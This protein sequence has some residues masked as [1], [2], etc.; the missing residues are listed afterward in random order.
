MTSQNDGSEC[1]LQF[2]WF[3][4]ITNPERSLL[5]QIRASLFALIVL[6]VATA[7]PVEK[8]EPVP[9]TIVD[10]QPNGEDLETA[11]QHHGGG[12][13]GGGHGGGG[14]G[15]GGHGG[16]GHGGGGHH[17]GGHHGGGSGGGG[18]HH[19]G[20]FGGGGHHHEG[21]G[22]FFGTR[23]FRCHRYWTGL[24]PE[25]LLNPFNRYCLIVG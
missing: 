16:G 10:V 18:G 23:G 21:L 24:E 3:Y 2:D 6:H 11:E 14:H 1:K 12:H 15:G 22:G 25:Y 7:Q 5:F 9:V 4:L 17:G 19:H 8:V 13:G 20:G